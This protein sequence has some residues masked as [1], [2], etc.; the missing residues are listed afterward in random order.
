M[1]KATRTGLIVAAVMAVIGGGAIATSVITKGFSEWNT[2]T[3]V[4]KGGTV[5]ESFNA[6]D[7][8]KATINKKSVTL[9]YTA[10]N[11]VENEEDKLILGNDEGTLRSLSSYTQINKLSLK[12][13]RSL[14]DA[15][16]YEEET[17]VN[18][19]SLLIEINRIDEATSEYTKVGYFDTVRINYKAR[20][21]RYLLINEESYADP[22][23]K[24]EN[25]FIKKIAVD[26]WIDYAI[27]ETNEDFPLAVSSFMLTTFSL[28]A[29][30][31]NTLEITSLE[32]VKKAAGHA[33][34][35]VGFAQ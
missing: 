10:S 31:D 25:A 9:T 14:K 12:D 22:D 18:G 8:F 2:V 35:T 3:N 29:L 7:G 28:D 27:A 33:N 21:Q 20:G 32:L 30:E 34:E 26:G 4:V 11:D 15:V 6:K 1:K 24:E 19:D 5:V 17:Y 13:Q 16:T 23:D